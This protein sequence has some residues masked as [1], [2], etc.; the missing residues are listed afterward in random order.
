MIGLG[1]LMDPT[2]YFEAHN[3]DR[4]DQILNQVFDTLTDGG[5]DTTPGILDGSQLDAPGR[6]PLILF[7]AGEE[8]KAKVVGT[9]FRDLDLAPAPPGVMPDGVDVAVV[10]TP[11]YE[12]PPAGTEP[13]VECP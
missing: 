5:F 3:I 10:V 2:N 9:Y 12:I 7:R 6:D 1:L 11:S 8:S 4:M 13:P